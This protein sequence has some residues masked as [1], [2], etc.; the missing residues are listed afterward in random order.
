ML[1]GPFL[2]VYNNG[3]V[4]LTQV[5]ITIDSG[6]CSSIALSAM[7]A[8]LTQLSAVLRKDTGGS[9]VI[10]SQE[11]STEHINAS[12]VYIIYK[13]PVVVRYV[14][15]FPSVVQRCCYYTL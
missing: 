10:I 6:S 15:V 7:K 12:I 5:V 2:F 4:Q 14:L 8:A 11:P 13:S 1:R 9:W 3:L